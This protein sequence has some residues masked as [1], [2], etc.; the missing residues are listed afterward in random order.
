ML[1][2]E[3]HEYA[4][5]SLRLYFEDRLNGRDRMFILSET[6]EAWEESYEDD[7]MTDGDT[8]TRKP[9][10]LA[11]K[12]RAMIKLQQAANEAYY[13]ELRARGKL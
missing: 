11:E 1:E 7:D 3:L 12:L 2:L 9:I 8:P 10:N 13:A 4:D 6:G 5:G